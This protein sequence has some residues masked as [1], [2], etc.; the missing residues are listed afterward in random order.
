[1]N[2][3]LKRAKEIRDEVRIGRNTASRV[4][5]LLVDIVG[6][7]GG[8]GTFVPLGSILLNEFDDL[9]EPG[10]YT[11]SLQD[12]TGEINGILVIS[13]HGYSVTSQ[14]RYELD[15]VYQRTFTDEGWEEWGDEF[16]YK[17]RKHIDNDTV[18]WDGNNQVIKAKGGVLETISIRISINP[19]NVGQCTISAT[20]DIINV[21]ES[22]DKSNYYIT[23]A[24]TGSV[25]I[26]IVPKDGYQVQKLNVDQVSQEQSQNILLKIWLLTIPC[27]CGWR[28]CWC[29]PTRTSSSAVTNHPF[30]IRDLENVLPQ[31][32]RIIRINSQ[33]IL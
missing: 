33:R 14:K 15:G 6:Q 26:K 31:L 21:V 2:D 11:Y 7:V 20:G 23:A 12:G 29:K 10:Y 8:A 13:S 18:Y 9:T 28:K 3:L 22:E 32:K 27:M 16:V 4:G 30:I 19:A 5:G 25:T 17:L 24:K 1:M